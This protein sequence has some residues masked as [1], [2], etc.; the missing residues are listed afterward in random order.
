M[1][2]REN[3]STGNIFAEQFFMIL[4]TDSDSRYPLMGVN[5]YGLGM[6]GRSYVKIKN[7]FFAGEGGSK[8]FFRII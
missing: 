6:V 1:G 8:F 4:T 2:F 7:I 5:I 3:D